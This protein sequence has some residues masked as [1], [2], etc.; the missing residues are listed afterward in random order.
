MIMYILFLPITAAI[1]TGL[2]CKKVSN[3]FAQ[4]FNS[5]L[6]VISALLSLFVFY[7]I[8][9]VGKI[10]QVDL[11]NWIDFGNFT[12]KWSIYAD[13]LTAI[14]LV[15]VTIISSIVHIYSIGY[16]HDDPNVP[17]FMAY[18]SL[19]TF[20]MLML[21][22]SNNLVQLFFGWEGVGLC[23]YLLIGFW[24]QKQSACDAAVKAFVVN[25]VGD[26]FFAIGI[27]SIFFMFDSVAFDQIFAN[28]AVYKDH[29]MSVMGM[30][31]HTLDFVCILL[32]IGCMGKSAQIGLHTW[33]PDA[34]EGPTPVSAL[35]HAAT[36][37]T[38]GV[39]LVARCSP[40]F[41]YAPFALDMVTVVGAVTCVFA[42]TI[43][44]VQNDI[45]KIVAYSTCSQL[46][47]MFFACGVSAY[48][49]AIFHLFTHAFFKALLFLGA[50][51][52][53]HV[54]SGEQDITK[55]G[56]LW[57]KIPFTYA[58]MWVG[59]LALC[60][61]WP[62]AG[63]Y[64]KDAIIE[65]AYVS[66][67]GVGEYAFS[68]GV[69][70]ACCTAFYSIRLLILV[71]HGTSKVPAKLSKHIHEPSLTMIVP[72]AL[73]SLGAV[74]SGVIGDK[75]FYILSPGLEFWHNSITI[76]A[77]PNILEKIHHLPISIK[78]TPL[79]AGVGGMILAYIFY[80]THPNLP[81]IIAARFSWLYVVVYNKYY[82]DELYDV[83]IVHN[84]KRCA[85]YFANT[86]EVK[87]IDGFG[88][89]GFASVVNR[90]SGYFSKL[91]TGYLYHYAL[92]ML[93][94]F[95]IFLTWYMLIFA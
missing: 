91:Q 61:I 43:A 84:L 45:K 35:I 46:G 31:F 29:Y 76:L 39:F 90:M 3:S 24:Y 57:K 11:F 56:G 25:R 82:V 12:I 85:N 8:V 86:T 36:M 75:I 55:M 87:V 94:G 53:I 6:L 5:S 88:P 49:A 83:L 42:A 73:L 93:L 13:S 1:F 32:F 68:M 72:L 70:A 79:V 26:V 54:L 19:F 33:L 58:M 20:F 17:K 66:G 60:G 67:S 2:L 21:V 22:T 9:V 14:M 52:V 37:V 4:I 81:K 78:I 41:E 15:V 69:F 92:V 74:F 51:S 63:Y 95:V 44:L 80:I 38:A 50:G 34:M 89:N 27:F 71:F 64:S 59:S 28:V 62:F 65:A 23:S 48:P 16:M 30:R 77:Q 18:L 47:Y 40:L 7:D 10:L